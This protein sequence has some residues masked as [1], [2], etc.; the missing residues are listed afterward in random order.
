LRCA[1]LYLFYKKGEGLSD[2]RTKWLV[3]YKDVK[4][5]D[6]INYASIKTGGFSTKSLEIERNDSIQIQLDKIENVNYSYD[7]S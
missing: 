3:K 7:V 1:Q 5:P 2:L 6:G 4:S